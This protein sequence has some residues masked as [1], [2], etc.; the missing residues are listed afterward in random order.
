MYCTLTEVLQKIYLHAILLKYNWLKVPTKYLLR[1]ILPQITKYNS[2]LV[3]RYWLGILGFV[4]Q[5]VY[6]MLG[7]ENTALDIPAFQHKYHL[8]L[9]NSFNYFNSHFYKCKPWNILKIFYLNLPHRAIGVGGRLHT[10]QVALIRT[11]W[12]PAGETFL[13]P[14]SISAMP[15]S[16]DVLLVCQAEVF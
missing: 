13:F 15:N 9:K 1:Q 10:F 8:S 3:L 7:R 6:R 12:S 11:K 16:T 5:H 14:P 2:Q 4:I